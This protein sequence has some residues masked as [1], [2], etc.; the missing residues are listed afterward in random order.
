[1]LIINTHDNKLHKFLLYKSL[2]ISIEIVR[3][4]CIVISTFT[5]KKLVH[6]KFFDKR[7][8]TSLQY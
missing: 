8:S 2:Y 1:M 3:H 4:M 7:N 5:Q 6:T